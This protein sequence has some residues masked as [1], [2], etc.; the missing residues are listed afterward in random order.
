MADIVFVV[1]IVG[2]F[3]LAA[4]FVAG[5]DRL[6]SGDEPVEPTAS[7]EVMP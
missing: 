1:M 2:F 6:V 5:C 3:G 4:A 7:T